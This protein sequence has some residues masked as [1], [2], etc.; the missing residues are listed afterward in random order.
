MDT[1]YQ[2]LI[3]EKFFDPGFKHGLWRSPILTS[4]ATKKEVTYNDLPKVQLRRR[5]FFSDMSLLLHQFRDTI[6]IFKH[7][8]VQRALRQKKSMVRQDFRVFHLYTDPCESITELYYALK[9]VPTFL[10]G[11]ILVIF[12]IKD[13]VWELIVEKTM[14]DDF[15]YADHL[16]IPTYL[17]EPRE[18]PRGIMARA[19]QVNAAMRVSGDTVPAQRV[20]PVYVSLMQKDS[21][22][23][24]MKDAAES[25]TIDRPE[26]VIIDDC[27]YVFGEGN[28]TRVQGELK[29]PKFYPVWCCSP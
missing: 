8:F 20:V 25:F 26:S 12:P 15:L 3:R 16:G 1:R 23:R 29:T 5:S 13:G 6:I 9:R 14:P 10:P 2:L 4:H 11:E 18:M 27:L 21:W 22:N 17:T 19:A 24:I 28:V 7:H